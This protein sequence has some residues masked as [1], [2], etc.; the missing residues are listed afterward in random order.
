M[1]PKINISLVYP[2]MLHITISIH[3]NCLEGSAVD[4]HAARRSAV[5]DPGHVHAARK[6]VS[7]LDTNISDVKIV[8]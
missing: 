1:T 3:E 7:H 8:L 6:C 5:L 4:N 2:L